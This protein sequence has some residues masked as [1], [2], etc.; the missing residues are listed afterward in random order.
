MLNSLQTQKPGTSFQIAVF[1]EFFDES[2]S[3]FD[4]FVGLAFKGL[5]PLFLVIKK[6]GRG[7]VYSEPYQTSKMDCFTKMFTTKP[8]TIFAKHSILD[9]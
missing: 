7:E 6:S 4:H 9:V 2:L 3:V 5:K 8:L 1:V